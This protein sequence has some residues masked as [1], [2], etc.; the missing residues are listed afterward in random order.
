MPCPRR[1]RL[2]RRARLQQAKAWIPTYRGKDLVRGYSRWFGTDRLCAILELRSLGVR[3]PEARLEQARQHRS[4]KARLRT[5]PPSTS[6]EWL[7]PATIFA[8][9]PIALWLLE[10]YGALDR[11]YNPTGRD[12]PRTD[13][14]QPDI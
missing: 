13:V 5:K 4:S 14:L 12:D 7:D 11:Y 2:D 6:G 8:G 9:D 3:I 1:L 10:E